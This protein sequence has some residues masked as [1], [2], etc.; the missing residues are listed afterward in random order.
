MC[1]NSAN[2][3]V[4]NII[5]NALVLLWIMCTH[6]IHGGPIHMDPLNFLLANNCSFLP[7]QLLP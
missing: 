1:A 6:E 2:W 5:S 7:T 3:E 4:K